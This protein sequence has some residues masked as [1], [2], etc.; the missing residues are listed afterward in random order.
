[1]RLVVGSWQRT[2]SWRERR[3]QDRARKRRLGALGGMG[4]NVRPRGEKRQVTLIRRA[5]G[6]AAAAARITLRATHS[7]GRS[8][9]QIRRSPCSDQVQAEDREVRRVVGRDEALPPY[10][11]PN[12]DLDGG[13]EG[14][15]VVAGDGQVQ[16][17]SREL[18]IALLVL[19]VGISITRR[20]REER[21][22]RARRPKRAARAASAKQTPASRRAPPTSSGSADT[23]RR[24]AASPIAPSRA[25]ATGRSVR[26]GGAGRHRRQ[27]IHRPVGVPPQQP[28]AER[29]QVVAVLLMQPAEDA[30]GGLWVS[31]AF[32]RDAGRWDAGD[33]AA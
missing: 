7:T 29:V 19:P 20:P 2:P 15:A 8:R 11:A 12:L 1:M 4:L 22:G 16:N 31:L 23:T 21:P 3:A 28:E 30:Q 18:E 14:T 27:S 24:G 17:P 9:G 32:A 10:R 6:S 33:W 13:V 25:R 5:E 26:P